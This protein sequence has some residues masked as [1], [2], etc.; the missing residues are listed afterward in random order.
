MSRKLEQNIIVGMSGGVDSSVAALLLAQAG[1]D[2]TGAFMR[3]WEADDEDPHCQADLDLTDAKS[4]CDEIGIELNTINFAEDYW[5]K[6]FQYFLDEY[7]AGRTPNPDVLCNQEIKFKA[8]LEYALAQGAEKIATGHYAQIH[9]HDGVYQLMKAID[10]N[11]DQTYFLYRLNQYQLQHSLFPLG[12]LTKP[13][14][15]EIAAKAAFTNHQKKDST[16]ICF[17][18]ER[19]FK[20]FLSEYLLAKPG[21]IKTVDGD[22]IGKHQG[23]MY[24]TNGQ[25]QGIGIGGMQ[26]AADKPW[27]VADKDIDNNVLIVAQGHDHPALF[28][29]SLIGEQVHWIAGVSPELPLDCCAKI[30]YRQVD[31]ACR[32]TRLE[33]DRLQV[34]FVQPQRAI[35]PGQS[36]VFYQGDVC[37]GG[38]IIQ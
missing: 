37:L 34:S 9:E 38:A 25:R 13:E 24:Y 28:K 31:Q 17:I 27:Y 10:S 20:A 36:V 8:F 6:V 3:N 29:E 30:R 35:A 23:L 32:V 12:Q 26:Q 11:K 22:I 14:V 15:R 33:E 18:G 4:V 1:Y 21:K 7:A 5:Q 19:K 16:G 2:V